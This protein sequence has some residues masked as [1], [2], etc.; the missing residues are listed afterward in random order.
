MP[1][2]GIAIGVERASRDDIDGVLN[3][4]SVVGSSGPEVDLCTDSGKSDASG[5]VARER[6]VRNHD[7]ISI[8]A[9]YKAPIGAGMD[10]LAL[11]GEERMCEEQEGSG[12]KRFK[13]NYRSATA[14]IR[15]PREYGVF[16]NLN[17]ILS[18]RWRSACGKSDKITRDS[19]IRFR[20]SQS[21]LA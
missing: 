8:A 11:L 3:G 14:P 6:V 16:G 19:N 12:E 15:R 18:I 4:G 17:R 5:A 13:A 20:L 1:P 21:G 10:P 9:I 7:A 2:P